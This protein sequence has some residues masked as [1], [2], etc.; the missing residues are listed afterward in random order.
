MNL[1][2]ACLGDSDADPILGNPT[3]QLQQITCVDRTFR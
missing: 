1:R 3:P 2:Q